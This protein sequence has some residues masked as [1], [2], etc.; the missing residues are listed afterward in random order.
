MASNN[1]PTMMEE[2]H[3]G[4]GGNKSDIK[5]NDINATK[6]FLNTETGK[7]N[8]HIEPPAEQ[9]V[10]VDESSKSDVDTIEDVHTKEKSLD[11]P[12]S[13]S[14]ATN[15]GYDYTSIGSGLESD[16]EDNTSEANS[17]PEK[18][19]GNKPDLNID[20]D[21][22][23]TV[24]LLKTSE[25]GKCYLLGTAHFSVE[26][27]NDV[28]KVIQAVQPHIVMVELCLDR[29]HVL[30]LDEETIL[31]EA[32]NINFSKIRDTIKENGLYTGLFQLLMLQ[33]SAHL[34][35]VLGLAPGGEFR[36][37][38]AE[39][40]KIPNCIVH[41]G[42]RPIKITFSRAIS[43][44]SWWQSIKLSW[45]L[46]TDKSPISQKDV[47][48]YKCRDSLEELMAELAGEFPALEEVFVKERDTYLTYSLQLACSRPL[49]GPDG[50]PI[51]PR[52]VGVVGMGHT[53]GII[54]NWGK[55]KR[56]QIAPIMSIPPPSL[57]GRILKFTF[58][59]SLVGS[60]IYIGYKYIPM[61][62][63]VIQSLK[64]SVAGLIKVSASQ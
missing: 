22:P 54:E 57:S 28:S 23:S 60:I 1:I 31:E 13:E 14:T 50:E 17:V 42:D 19:Q 49:V 46:L 20:D 63:G 64:S 41:M 35:K 61:P 11:T 58:K 47:E 2:K 33:M 43:A 51:P 62:T 53:L 3:F 44:L 12:D 16:V 30:Q 27:Q 9:T 6:D 5:V 10:K 45:H 38:F 55:V 25:G 40:K 34:T 52:V 59:A 21:L 32:K 36:R 7:H 8:N 26:S 56:S 29:V 15:K 24:T 18:P 37:A 39:A 48:K 4:Y